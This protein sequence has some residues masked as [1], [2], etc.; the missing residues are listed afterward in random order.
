MRPFNRTL[1]RPGRTLARVAR[2]H[3][4]RWRPVHDQDRSWPELREQCTQV[5]VANDHS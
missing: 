5:A 2:T 4:P 1:L 3:K